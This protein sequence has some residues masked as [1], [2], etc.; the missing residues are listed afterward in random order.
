MFI[1]ALVGCA[2]LPMV[3]GLTGTVVQSESMMPH[4]RIGDIVLSRPLPAQAATP[5]GLV[6]TFPAAPGSATPGIRL[7]RV[8]GTNPDDTLITAGDANRDMDSAPLDRADIIAVASLLIPWI[9]LPAFWLQHGLIL[10]FAGWL[11]V[12]LL[13]LTIEFFATRAENRERRGRRPEHIRPPRRRRALSGTAH[14]LPV[15]ALVLCA[16]LVVTAPNAPAASAAFTADT[17]NTASN[18]VAAVD[19]TPTKLVFTAN[20]SSS[21]GGTTFATQPAVKVQTSNGGPT[22]STVPVTLS[23]TTPAGATLACSSNPVAA[24]AGTAQ[25]SGCKIDKA[26]TY[27][28]TATS[29]NLSGAT[30]TNITVTVGPA[31]KLLF[32]ATPGNTARNTA[33]TKQPVVVVQDAGGN[34]VTS[35]TI[36]ITLSI[37]SGTLTCTS[38]PKN[39]VAGVAT[40]AGCR[41]DQ[42]GNHILTARSGAL[43][44][45]S[46]T[47]SIFSVASKLTFVTS[48]ASTVSGTPF[49]SQPV[50]AI[51]D[52]TGYT[53]SGTNPITLTLTTPA[54][55]TLACSPNPVSA[56][57]GTATFSGCAV[58]K[59]GTYTL[60]ASTTGLSSA[61]S[62]SFTISAGPPTRLAFTSSPSSSTSS[63]SFTTQPIVAILDNFGNTTGSTSSVTLAVTTPAGTSLAC[64]SNPKVAI[65]G[66]ATFSG[67]RIARAGTY[68]LS[69]TASGL[70]S[71]A[72][73]SFTI[74]AGPAAKVAITTAPTTAVRGVAFPTQPAIAIQDAAGNLVSTTTFVSLTI[75]S[76][77]GGANLGCFFNPILTDGGTG[78]FTGCRIDRAGTFT[79]T[80]ASLGLT[81]GQSTSFVVG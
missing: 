52:A 60:T 16:A 39:A 8:V 19:Q 53:T 50:V 69:A 37:T 15:A 31:I 59:A 14:A 12:T 75:T 33:F 27:T 66:I 25:F 30:S 71:A 13:A 35:S 2:T 74:S 77:T 23:I 61:T 20:P 72:S 4:I 57:N 17:V 3:F 55:A 48:P 22:V 24:V 81:P 21:T 5:L 68:T 70:T 78:T 36:P 80:A 47:F 49:A 6:V 56:I 58:G 41:I 54:G 42:T 63:T 73:G 79:L 76:P 9:G 34:T 62:T 10:P 64:T 38:N 29:P 44:G 67:C 11:T 40:F 28:L 65:T 43:S 26:G 32:S 7:H 45:A 51:Q 18:W 1:V 46:S